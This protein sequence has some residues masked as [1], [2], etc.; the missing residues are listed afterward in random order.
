MLNAMPQTKAEECIR[1]NPFTAEFKHNPYPVYRRLRE[2][3]PVHKTLGMWVLTRHADVLAI[4]RDRSFSAGLIPQ[5]VSMHVEKSQI[6]ADRVEL[7]GKKSLVFTDNP[8]HARL[9]GIVNRAFTP[10]SIS[11]LRPRVATLV[12]QFLDRVSTTSEF[13]LIAELAEPLP[14]LVM[15]DW[16]RLPASIRDQVGP[17]AH[18]IR[19]LLEPGLMKPS[20]LS[21]VHN[22]VDAFGAALD[23]AIEYR[24]RKPGD[25]LISNLLAVQTSGGDRLSSDELCVI[26]MMFFAA[27]NETTKSL[28]GNAFLALA[29]HRDQDALL[30]ER[31]E[32]VRNFI[33]EVLRYDS[34][35][36]VTKRCATRDTEI[37]GELIRVGDRVLLCLGGANRDPAIFE[38][39]DLFDITR[40]AQRHLAF[41][42]GMHGCLGGALAELQTEIAFEWVLR[43]GAR[44]ELTT[45]QP[46]WQDESIILRGLQRFPVVMR[47]AR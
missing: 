24:R 29:Q 22:A 38:H 46:E 35:V 11:N 45:E 34:P 5:M 40:P 47:G 16:M 37:G 23:E 7:L 3:K 6:T 25:D 21:R 14:S 36:Q 12:D 10:Q 27:A 9:R 43:R 44:I 33:T 42:F 4:L 2:I 41:G 18:D 8:D 1:F 31:P 39:P 20:E 32:L 30:R 28:I 19:F 26:C 17:W 15:Q 13:D